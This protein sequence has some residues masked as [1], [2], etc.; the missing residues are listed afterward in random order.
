MRPVSP[1][2]PR[3]HPSFSRAA[4]RGAIARAAVSGALALALLAPAVAATS[5]GARAAAPLR[6]GALA[7]I[8]VQQAELTAADGAAKEYF[9][10]AVAVDGDTAVV[11]AMG[12]TVAGRA[13]Q[14]AAYVFVRSGGVWT[15]QAG[16]LA[17]DGAAQDMFGDAVAVSG[18]LAV[19]G[20]PGRDVGSDEGQGVMYV[21][22]RSGAVWT[23]IGRPYDVEGEAG[24]EFGK[25]VAV[26]GDTVV[27]G[28]PFRLV[29]DEV[30]QGAAFVFV[31]WG[32]GWQLQARLTSA[33]GLS[34][35]RFGAS[36]ALSGDTIVVGAPRFDVGAESAQGAAY[37]FRRTGVDWDQEAQL[38]AADGVGGDQF[39]SS[40][41]VA[42]DTA[43]VGAPFRHAGA[44]ADAGAAYVYVRSGAQWSGQAVLV[45]EQA[46]SHYALGHDVAVS[47]D[48]V[49]AGMPG[50]SFGPT[51]DTA[52][53]F[54]RSGSQW[55]ERGDLHADDGS[56]ED[57]FGSDVAVSGDTV[58]V[59]AGWHEV[60]GHATQGAA[61]VFL[62][63]TAAPVT[64]AQLAPAANAAG[65][66]DTPVT[67]TL[68]A[69][70][71]GWSAP[72]SE[73]RLQGEPAWTPYAA[74]F[75]VSVEG[76]STWEYRSTDAAGNVEAARTFS[77][78]LDTRAPT[79]KAFRA[80]VRQG[81]TV[82][83]QYEVL[84][85]VPG[86]GAADVTLQIC[87]GRVVKRTLAAGAGPCN[88]RRSYRWRCGLTPGRYT[89][90]VLATDAAGNG[91]SR[92]GAARL[93]VR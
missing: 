38:I 79:T 59:G 81:R 33:G 72:E 21:F 41:D 63:D 20:A 4:R 23:Q 64:S 92:I 11:G 42:G 74:P 44:R 89:L 68:T 28:V 6:A 2:A 55:S 66:N 1:R 43:V 80:S 10:F 15:Q 69:T 3:P 73:Y 16:L 60:D 82:R 67:V 32:Q 65:W 77:V 87:K 50:E 86:C 51:P 88:E 17:A 34:Y 57:L 29:G 49:I 70:D 84:D 93:T 37:V 40:V 78:S 56:G 27:G 36:L 25:A 91:Q 83:L 19:V 9:G 62:L 30:E 12:T 61:Y 13:F 31:P 53:V 54:T 39:G 46:G 18:D 58:L 5:A 52:V 14:G 90:K 47:G 75:A 45:A 26:S 7:Q 85:A 24:D 71:G 8:A 35:D 48:T 22:E 76:L